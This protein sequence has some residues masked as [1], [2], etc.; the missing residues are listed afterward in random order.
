MSDR[1]AEPESPAKARLRVVYKCGCT[2]P[3]DALESGWCAGCAGKKRKERFRQLQKKRGE[4]PQ[5][6]LRLPVGSVK[7]LTWD[8]KYWN[9][10]LSVPG[11]PGPFT[12]RA[13]TEKA[14]YH[15]LHAQYETWLKLVAGL[16]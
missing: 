6:V 16:P 3:V 10:T 15:G 14:C 7:T 2:I 13:D 12:F 8:G 1:P 11:P 9:G 5:T 4:K